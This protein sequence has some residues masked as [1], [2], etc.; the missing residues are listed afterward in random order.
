MITLSDWTVLGITFESVLDFDS[1][2]GGLR[3]TGSVLINNISQYKS[4]NLQ[5]IQRQTLRSWAFVEKYEAP[6][7]VGLT[8]YKWNYWSKNSTWN[9]VLVV[10]SSI[11]TGIDPSDIYKSYTGTNKIIIDDYI[12]LKVK[13]YEYNTYKGITWQSRVLPAV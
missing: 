10:S 4:T 3:I 6:A 5:E 12:P 13:N 8:V 2:V 11:F 7:P 1:Y 9:Q